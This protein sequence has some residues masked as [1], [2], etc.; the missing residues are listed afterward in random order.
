MD[1]YFKDV[2]GDK[3]VMADNQWIDHLEIFEGAI[4]INLYDEGE[5]EGDGGQLSR[6]CR[7]VCA[8]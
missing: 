6:V 4:W 1:D 2:I 8:D 7:V 5:H 3:L